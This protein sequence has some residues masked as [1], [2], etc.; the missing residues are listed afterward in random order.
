MKRSGKKSVVPK[1]V[2]QEERKAKQE[3]SRKA[4]PKPEVELSSESDETNS[5]YVEYLRTY[6][7]EED[8]SDAQTKAGLEADSAESDASSERTVQS[9]RRDPP[10]E[11]DSS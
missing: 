10:S 11:E 8:Q 5:D 6:R 1:R 4:K 7:P 9:K 2:S 3:K